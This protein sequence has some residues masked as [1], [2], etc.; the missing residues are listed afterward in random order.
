A[1]SIHAVKGVEFTGVV[2]TFVPTDSNSTAADFTATIYWG[3]GVS[4]TGVVSRRDDGSY[5]VRGTHTYYRQTTGSV[6]ERFS[7]TIQKGNQ[8]SYDDE[9][10]FVTIDP[11]R[12]NADGENLNFRQ[13]EEF[14]TKVATFTSP[15]AGATADQFSLVIDWGDGIGSSG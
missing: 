1:K 10:Y 2:G 8:S 7:V 11:T 5:E 6:Y 14:T 13:R 4:S 12:I 15:I 9:R 3:D